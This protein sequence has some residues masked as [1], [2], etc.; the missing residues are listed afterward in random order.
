MMRDGVCSERVM[1]E[2]PTSGIGSG[3]KQDWPTPTASEHA[4]G[5]PDGKMQWMLTHAAKSGCSTRKEY[6]DG[7]TKTQQK[8]TTPCA[9]DTGAR[10][11]KYVQGGT[12]LSMQAK[13]QLN[14][15][16]VEWLM[17]W[18]IGWTDL[19]PLA[20]PQAR[21]WKEPSMVQNWRSPT[22]HDW[23]NTKCSTQIYV[24]DQV[25]DRSEG[26]KPS[27]SGQLNPPWVEWLMG[28]PLFWTSLEPLAMDWRDWQTDPA[29]SGEVPRVATG[30]KHRVERL[31]AIGNGQVPAVAALA[32]RILSGQH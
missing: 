25:E 8:W 5:T 2:H 32:W 17:G 7:G 12:A 24:S 21:D 4:A 19:K 18:P 29:D 16:W 23:K 9:D 14:P 27:Q 1:Q 22:A 6:K 31:K 30:V 11:K 26:A 10:K 3:L 13:G 28:W 15:P 20:T